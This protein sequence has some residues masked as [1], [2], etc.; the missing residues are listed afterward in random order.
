VPRKYRRH[1]ITRK[2]EDARV[3]YRTLNAIM[4][5]PPATAM[6]WSPFTE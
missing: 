3:R 4:F 2:E 5:D 6:Y 1:R